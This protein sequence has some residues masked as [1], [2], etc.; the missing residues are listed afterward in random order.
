M[1]LNITDPPEDNIIV[2]V[3]DEVNITCGY[4]LTLSFKLSLTWI[5]DGVSYSSSEIMS[6]SIYHSP[7]VSNSE[8]TI[9]TIYSV[10]EQMNGTTIQCEIPIS[11]PVY[12][13][14]GTLTVIGPPTLPVIEISERRLTSLVISWDTFS[15]TLCGDV[16]YNVTL[17]DGTAELVEERT[18]TSNTISFTDLDND[19][20][21]EV[22]VLAINNAGPGTVATTNVTTLTPSVPFPPR[23]LAVV[24]KFVDFNPIVNISWNPSQLVPNM[25]EIVAYNVSVTDEDDQMQCYMLMF[26]TTTVSTEDMDNCLVVDV[27]RS[28]VVAVQ[29]VNSVGASETSSTSFAVRWLRSA[30]ITIPTDNQTVSVLCDV[31]ESNPPV[32]C[33]VIITCTTCE[34]IISREFTGSIQQR[35]MPQNSY[36]ICV[37]VI[38]AEN[39]TTVEDCNI[40]QTISVPE[41]N[42]NSGIISYNDHS[43]LYMTT[44]CAVG[45]LTTVLMM[46]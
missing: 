1:C 13:S 19:T 5:I 38:I 42:T 9:L 14:N 2:C 25:T 37:Q 30:M 23:N 34:L 10:S 40:L 6:S 4:T 15:H 24:V 12:S 33:R 21:Y 36:S 16:T 27:G 32:K 7:V 11:P 8:D 45:V 44:F 29:S 17:S 35:V 28:Y 46:M 18:T 26:D 20:Q 22:T 41:R 43:S 31:N 39:G 3:G